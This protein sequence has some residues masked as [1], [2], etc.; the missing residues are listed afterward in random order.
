MHQMA[1]IESIRN[2]FD[3]GIVIETLKNSL[4]VK[5]EMGLKD[6]IRHLIFG[7]GYAEL[8]PPKLSQ[9]R[10]LNADLMIVD[11]REE[12]KYVLSHIKGAVSHPFDDFLKSILMDGEYG[13]FKRKEMVLVCDTGHQ[14]RVAASIL[15]EEGFVHAFSLSRGMRRWN[16]WQNLL[17]TQKGSESKRCPTCLRS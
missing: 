15:A 7:K 9:Q 10:A 2:F 3:C 12:R 11:L 1:R 5:M 14:S 8:T 4:K 13:E 16:R 17:R 6:F